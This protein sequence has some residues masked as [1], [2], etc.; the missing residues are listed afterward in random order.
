M[1]NQDKCPLIT[2]NYIVFKLY[3]SVEKAVYFY[4]LDAQ[5]DKTQYIFKYQYVVQ[6]VLLNTIHILSG[7]QVNP[8]VTQSTQKIPSKCSTLLSLLSSHSQ[9]GATLFF[10]LIYDTKLFMFSLFISI[11][12]NI[13]F[14]NSFV[15]N[16][17]IKAKILSVAELRGD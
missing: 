9:V 10:H 14:E 11:W 16:C 5:F 7:N 6:N 1:G 12:Y 13:F 3:H 8:S 17:K 2:H 15:S 4:L